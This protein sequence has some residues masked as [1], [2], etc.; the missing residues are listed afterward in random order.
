MNYIKISINV[1]NMPEYKADVLTFELGEIGFSTFETENDTLIAYAK[2]TD[3]SAES[4]KQM[5]E[6]N[7]LSSD[8][9]SVEDVEDKDWNEEWEKNYFQPIVVDGGESKCVIHSSF[10]T[11]VPEAEYDIVINPKM[12]FGTGHH[13][14]TSSMLR[15]I[16]SDSLQG[17]KVLDM[18]C[19]TAVL[20]ILAKMRGA[21]YVMGVDIDEWCK[22]NATESAAINNIDM[23]IKLGDASILPKENTFDV[24]LANIN[25]NILLADMDKY[26]ACLNN[27][28]N[29][30]MSGFYTEDIP[31]IREKAESLGLNFV[32]FKE[33][34]NWVA[35][36]FVK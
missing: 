10:H 36:K 2:Q 16:L 33:K 5:A 1:A 3:F 20:G 12:S 29:L 7:D 30:Y 8:D 26:V 23:E 24:I 31:V 9:Y 18:G 35:V 15:W 17:K 25:R 13:E 21:D 27:G 11:D 19:G 32:D 14:T 22:E 6:D 28:G 34:N 4:L